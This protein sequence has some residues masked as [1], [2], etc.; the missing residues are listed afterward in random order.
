MS[1]PVLIGIDGGGSGTR[2]VVGHGPAEV[3]GAGEAGA[4]CVRDVGEEAAGEQV[5]AAV[6]AARR[7][8]GM[9][10]V[11]AEGIFLGLGGVATDDDR[12]AAQRLV[13][14]V[15]HHPDASIE[16]G[17]DLCI[18]HAGALARVRSP[19]RG[20]VLIAGLFVVGDQE[21]GRKMQ[22][23]T[24]WDEAVDA[25]DEVNARIRAELRSRRLGAA[26]SSG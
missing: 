3:L 4:S 22:V 17:H 13:E 15:P 11:E 7:D 16:V 18:A 6:E 5:L 25:A 21:A 20:V 2:A 12:A 1:R 9:G 26:P 19:R 23:Y 14:R 24:A 10:E 8:A